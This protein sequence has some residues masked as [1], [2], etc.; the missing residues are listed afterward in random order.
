EAALAHDPRTAPK[1]GQLA[2]DFLERRKATH[3][4]GAE[5]GYRWRKHLAPFFN[6]LLPAEIDQARI[7]AFIEAKLAEG[8]NPATIRIF[9]AILSA[10][11]ADL[12]ERGLIQANPWRSLPRATMGLMRPTHDPRTT[13]FIEKLED[14]RRTYLDLP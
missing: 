5:D 12:G 11:F 8:M 13:P 3:H 14:V 4:A 7:K 9:V 10:L 2:S 1:L 6:N